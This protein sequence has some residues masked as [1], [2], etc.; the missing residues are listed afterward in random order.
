MGK[1]L[2]EKMSKCNFCGSEDTYTSKIDPGG[3]RAIISCCNK[4][5]GSGMAYEEVRGGAVKIEW[6]EWDIKTR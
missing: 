2:F 5:G 6:Y 4:C 1:K 3:A